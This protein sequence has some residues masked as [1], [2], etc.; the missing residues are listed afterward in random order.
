MK[1]NYNRI[2][3]QIFTKTKDARNCICQFEKKNS[4]EI[5][6]FLNANNLEVVFI[7]L[8][9]QLSKKRTFENWMTK[10]TPIIVATN[11]FGMGIDKAN[12][13]IVIH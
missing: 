11:A 13:G 12:V 7:M 6:A 3:L 5:S 10:K 4:T 8:D 2:L 9:Y 1:T